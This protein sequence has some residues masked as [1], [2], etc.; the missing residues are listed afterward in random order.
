[1]QLAFPVVLIMLFVSSTLF[2]QDLQGQRQ[3]LKKQLTEVNA[4]L[5][6]AADK[7]EYDELSKEREAI[8]AKIKDVDAKLKADVNAIKRINEG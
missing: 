1:M 6:N 5:A 4:K 2:A 7:A 3:Q 8:V